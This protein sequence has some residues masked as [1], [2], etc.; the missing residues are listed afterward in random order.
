MLLKVVE[1]PPNPDIRNLLDQFRVVHY[2][3]E[4]VKNKHC[5]MRCYVYF[6]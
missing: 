5:R 4:V 3:Y 2:C 1:Q 6:M